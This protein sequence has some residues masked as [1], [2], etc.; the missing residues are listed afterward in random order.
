MGRDYNAEKR[1]ADPSAAHPPQIAAPGAADGPRAPGRLGAWAVVVVGA[2]WVFAGLALGLEFG[3][4]HA[5]AYRHGTPAT[6]TIDHCVSRAST[7]GDDD[8]CYGRWGTGKD[9]TGPIF[10]QY[11]RHAGAGSQLDV[12]VFSNRN[13]TWTA[14]TASE[15]DPKYGW[16]AGG[17]VAIAVG[18]TLMWSARRRIKTGRWPSSGRR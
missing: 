12:H 4:G 17:V 2:L 7:P 3:V 18:A 14:Y 9:S 8:I 6:A 16:V 5:L 1:I 13:G 11:D 10:G 15:A